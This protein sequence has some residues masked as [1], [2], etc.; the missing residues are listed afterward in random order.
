MNMKKNKKNRTFKYNSVGPMVYYR[1]LDKHGDLVVEG[2]DLEEVLMEAARLDK[3]TFERME[4]F[5][6]TDGYQE[7]TPPKLKKLQHPKPT[8]TG[9]APYGRARVRRGYIRN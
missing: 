1:A 6:A 9:S 7:F 8:R 4:I 2:A 5:E 3:V